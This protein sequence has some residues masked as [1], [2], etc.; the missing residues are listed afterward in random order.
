[1]AEF[2]EGTQVEVRYP[3]DEQQARG[4][5]ESWPWMAGVIEDECGP[6]EWLVVVVSREVATGENGTPAQDGTPD[7]ALYFPCCFRDSSEIRYPRD[8]KDVWRLGDIDTSEMDREPIED[9]I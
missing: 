2:P 1:M 9:D 6:D 4:D 3:L 5:R 7:D 8:G